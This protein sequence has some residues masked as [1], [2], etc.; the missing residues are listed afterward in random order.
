MYGRDMAKQISQ[1]LDNLETVLKQAGLT[2]A[3][4]VRLN[5]YTTDMTAFFNAASAFLP[6]LV[7]SGCKPSST[8]LGV[9]SLFHPEIMIELEATAVV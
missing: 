9:A 1:A 4:V 8:L 6:R 5:Y 2:L 3:N 7:A